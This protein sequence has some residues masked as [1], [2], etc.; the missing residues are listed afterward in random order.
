[1]TKTLAELEAIVRFRGD[2]RNTLRFPSANVQG[3]IQAAFNEFYELVVDLNEGYYDT[4]ATLTTTAGVGFV[5]L[6][7]GTWRIRRISRVEGDD[8]HPMLLL[9][10]ADIE[11]FSGRQAR[12]TGY[13]PT[14]RGI[15]LYHT[16]D[17]VYSLRMVYT[18]VAPTLGAARDYYNGWEEY[19]VYGALLRLALNEE[20]DTREWQAQLDFQRARIQRGAAQ[21][22]AQ[23]PE[24]LPIHDGWYGD[25]W[26]GGG[27]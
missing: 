25:D 19:A 16:P 18:P 27:W 17:G 11:R 22:R 14:E 4:Q 3:E 8:F 7:A 9:G 12:P 2:F 24:L 6:P 5:A 23:G 20:R 13:L 1:M 10:V 15:D 26:N 21:R